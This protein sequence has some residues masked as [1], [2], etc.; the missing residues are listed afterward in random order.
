MI[1]IFVIVLMFIM[2]VK[3]LYNHVCN[4]K[5]INTNV[6]ITNIVYNCIIINDTSK[7]NYFY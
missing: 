3:Y 4:H 7:H 2:Y 6:Y 5:C 1:F